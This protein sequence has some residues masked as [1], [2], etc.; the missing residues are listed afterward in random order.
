MLNTTGVS[1]HLQSAS[2]DPLLLMLLWRREL[3]PD[4]ERL[5][6]AHRLWAAL[7]PQQPLVARRREPRDV[8]QPHNRRGAAR[9]GS[10]LSRRRLAVCVGAEASAVRLE[11]VLP[12]RKGDAQ[13]LVGPAADAAHSQEGVSRRPLRLRHADLLAQLRVGAPGNGVHVGRHGRLALLG[14]VVLLPAREVVQLGQRAVR[15]EREQDVA[16][17]RVDGAVLEAALQQVE[18]RRLVQVV[19]RHHVWQVLRVRRLEARDVLLLDEVLLPLH[20]HHQLGRRH[21]LLLRPLERAELPPA[22]DGAPQRRACA[23]QLHAKLLVAHLGHEALDEL[24]RVVLHLERQ[25]GAVVL[26]LEQQPVDLV[27]PV[28]HLGELQVEG[29]Q[30]DVP[31]QREEGDVRVEHLHVGVRHRRV[32]PVRRQRDG[33]EA[34]VGGE[35]LC[36]VHEALPPELVVRQVQLEQCGVVCERRRQLLRRDVAD[37]AVGEVERCEPCVAAQRIGERRAQLDRLLT[38]DG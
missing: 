18:E 31:G 25:L 38:E 13:R 3:D 37:G 28:D 24:G 4:L 6:S 15:V 9:R 36:D 2:H 20:L 26:P 1:A 5:A 14:G 19:H 33:L 22:G 10:S 8:A 7:E 27:V 34:D 17:P 11:P 21:P 32:D 12:Q 35:G 30:V 16:R 23:A 29:G